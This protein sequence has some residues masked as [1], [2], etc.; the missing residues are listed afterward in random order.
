MMTYS[1]LKSKCCFYFLCGADFIC[2][3]TNHIAWNNLAAFV[4]VCPYVHI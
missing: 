4:Q 1:Y 2:I 3:K